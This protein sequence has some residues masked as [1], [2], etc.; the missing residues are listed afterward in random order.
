MRVRATLPPTAA[1]VPLGALAAGA[2]ALIAG[3]AHATARA[4]E[5]AQWQQAE[6]AFLVSSGKAALTIT[7]TALASAS[8][9]RKVIMPAY[10][11]YSV[12]SAVVKAGLEVVPCDVDPRTLDF[13]LG[14]LESLLDEQ[15]LCVIATHLFG[16]PADVEAVLARCRPKG[17]VVIEDAAQAM[18]GTRNGVLLG[19]LGDV[20]IFSLGRGKNVSCGGGGAIVTKSRSI[21]ASL[22]AVCAATHQ[23]SRVGAAVNWA[24]LLATSL[25]IHPSWYWLPAGL[26]FLGLGETKFYRDFPVARMSHARA[27]TLVGWQR[28]LAQD[29]R[30]RR[31]QAEALITELAL[32]APSIV[33]LAKAEAVYLRLPVLMPDHVTKEWIL[34][35]SAVRGLG[36]SR[37]YPD[38]ITHIPELAGSLAGYAD[39]GARSLIERLVTL[40]THRYVSA[41]HRAAIVSLC[42]EAEARAKHTSAALSSAPVAHAGLADR[43]TTVP[44]HAHLSAVRHSSPGMKV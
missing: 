17:I 30:A 32:S 22:Q 42:A 4:Q 18:G 1:P 43:G 37:A 13:N 23:E 26:P 25:L 9:R 16:L 5:L 8:S 38:T 34:H 15:T 2:A 12:P 11:C 35:E 39:A 40:P 3:H 20:G 27:A 10:T 6:Q 44:D 19:S 24:E 31:E 41:A 33:A 21:A 28:R 29:N 7:L 14:C 36:I